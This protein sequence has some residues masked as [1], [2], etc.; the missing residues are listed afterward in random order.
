MAL[1][2]S[3]TASVVQGVT[4]QSKGNIEKCNAPPRQ[5]RVHT[6][7]CHRE[8]AKAA[9][10]E[11]WLR[12]LSIIQTDLDGC[13]ICAIAKRRQHHGSDDSFNQKL[14]PHGYYGHL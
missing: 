9:I 1:F 14:Q 3:P 11:T 2:I 7:E 13:A 4:D 8:V 10:A 12:F 6:E 5:H